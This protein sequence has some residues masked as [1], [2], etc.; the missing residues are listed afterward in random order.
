LAPGTDTEGFHAW[1]TDG[2][3]RAETE[4]LVI[5]VQDGAFHTS[6]YQAKVLKNGTDPQCRVCWN[7]VETIGHILSIGEAHT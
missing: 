6:R 1:V 7:G 4:A 2:W 5:V 3:V